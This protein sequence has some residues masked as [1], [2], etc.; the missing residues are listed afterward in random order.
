MTGKSK[1]QSNA[2]IRQE[3]RE[4]YVKE[5]EATIEALRQIRDDSNAAPGERLEAIKLLEKT[6]RF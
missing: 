1:R 2:A 5:Q 3:Q 6:G 4:R